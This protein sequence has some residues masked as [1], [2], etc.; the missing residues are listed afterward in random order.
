VG[1]RAQTNEAPRR[2]NTVL[3][4]GVPSEKVHINYVL[5][6]PFGASGGFTTPNRDSLSYRIPTSVD[7]KAAEHIERFRSAEFAFLGAKD[8]PSPQARITRSHISR[9][10]VFCPVNPH[11]NH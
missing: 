2:F 8:K 11:E 5:D 3:L 1:A 10:L 4:G 6:G 9:S 7:G